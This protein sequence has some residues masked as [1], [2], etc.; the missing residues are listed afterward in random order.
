MISAGFVF[1]LLKPCA[2]ATFL[3]LVAACGGGDGGGE[4]P[5]GHALSISNLR[6]SPMSAA[7]LPNGT[8]TID[9]TVDFTDAGGDIAALRMV[10]SGGADLAVPTPG[11]AGVKSGAAKGSFVVLLSQAGNYTFELW[12]VDSQGKESNRLSGA[13][14]VVPSTPAPTTTDVRGTWAGNWSGTDP[15]LGSLRGTWQTTLEQSEAQLTGVSV[16]LGDTDCIDAQVDGSLLSA[17]ESN[18]RL[19]RGI[20]EPS[21]W[22]ATFSV[23]EDIVRG[24]WTLQAGASGEFIGRKVS[25][26]GGPRVSSVYPPSGRPGAIVTILGDRLGQPE[27]GAPLRFNATAQP[28]VI[29]SSDERW[30]ARVPDGATSG[31]MELKSSTGRALAPVPFDVQPSSP[32]LAVAWSTPSSPLPFRIAVSPDGSKLYVAKSSSTTGFSL[33]VFDTAR[34][35]AL[36]SVSL[37]NPPNDVAASPDGRSLYVAVPGKVQVLDAMRG[38]SI[39]SIKVAS[40]EHRSHVS[41]SHDGSLMLVSSSS[42]PTPVERFSYATM[43]RLK[44][45]AQLWQIAY[46]DNFSFGGAAFSPDGKTAYLVGT[47]TA[48]GFLWMLDVERGPDDAAFAT[49]VRLAA[50]PDQVAVSPDGS[51][52]FITHALTTSNMNIVSRVDLATRD[53]TTTN[54]WTP[55]VD[56]AFSPNGEQVFV[57]TRTGIVVLGVTAGEIMAGPLDI[58]GEPRGIAMDPAG[59]LAYVV[60]SDPDAVTAI[61][62]MGGNL[63]VLG[64]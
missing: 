16:L 35:V 6:Y 20:C 55:L 63:G 26:P 45:K 5:V 3:A 2:V 24:T 34:H 33:E 4:V 12:A 31:W 8:A 1:R 14:A 28:F 40:N 29:S 59:K 32:V 61:G 27:V 11:L 43:I 51:T 56:L 52:L 15:A 10:S 7:Q 39:D 64:R 17:L 42:Y 47:D 30:V 9:A 58:G 22:R 41:I 21:Q 50:R 62:T 13:F 54:L 49:P 36:A 48:R 46:Q 44:D 38:R 23:V 18:G 60:Q 57:A 25:E 19:D 53:V 37:G